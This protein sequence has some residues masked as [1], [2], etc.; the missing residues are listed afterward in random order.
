MVVNHMT[1]SGGSGTGSGGSGFHAPDLSFPAFGPNDF[2]CCNSFGAGNCNDGA[3]CYTQS[4][5]IGDYGNPQ[6][7]M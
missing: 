3:K 5:D 7:V 2:N 1:G 6:E 4:C